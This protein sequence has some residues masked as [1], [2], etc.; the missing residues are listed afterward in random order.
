MFTRL[1]GSAM[2][3][4]GA[5]YTENPICS[6]WIFLLYQPKICLGQPKNLFAHIQTKTLFDSNGFL[7]V[8]GA[9]AMYEWCI[10]LDP[11]VSCL[12]SPRAWT[13]A[14]RPI[15]FHL[16]LINYRKTIEDFLTRFNLLYPHTTSDAIDSGYFIYTYKHQSN[17]LYHGHKEGLPVLTCTARH[18]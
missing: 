3:R 1:Q 7:S 2:K 13:R 17:T 8:Q 11:R 5:P 6:N 9:M 16:F 4:G 10:T 12:F 15:L 18:L 14:D